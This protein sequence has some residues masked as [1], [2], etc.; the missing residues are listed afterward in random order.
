MAEQEH[1]TKKENKPQEAKS[2]EKIREMKIVWPEEDVKELKALVK[3]DLK[4]NTIHLLDT[5]VDIEDRQKKLLAQNIVKKIIPALQKDF[6]HIVEEILSEKE[7]DWLLKVEKMV[8]EGAE[9]SIEKGPGCVW[10][11]FKKGRSIRYV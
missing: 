6:P 8:D 2:T 10:L 11:V 1:K 9:V 7:R 4:R 3:I 5:E